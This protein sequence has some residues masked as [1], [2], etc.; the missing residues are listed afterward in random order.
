MCQMEIFFL[1]EKSWWK[2]SSRGSYGSYFGV[3]V[4]GR[5]LHKLTNKKTTTFPSSDKN[6]SELNPDKL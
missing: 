4:T 3:T 2:Y 5:P 6:N 1:L